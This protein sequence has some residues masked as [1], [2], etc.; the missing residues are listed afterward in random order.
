MAVSR[1]TTPAIANL[2]ITQAKIASSVDL[3]GAVK[4]ANVQVA[5]SSWSLLDDTAVDTDGGYV[6]VNGT[7]FVSGCNVLVGNVAATSVTFVSATQLRVQVPATAAGSYIM[8]VS[9]PDGATGIRLNAITFSADPQWVTDST[10]A[11]QITDSAIS[12]QLSAT[13]ATSYSLQAGS[14][15]PANTTLAS[16]G[17]FSGTITG[18]NEDTVYNFTVV[19]TDAENQDSPRAFSVTVTVGDTYFKETVL[20]LNSEANTL[21][22]DASNNSF[23]ITP[24]GDVRPSAFSPYN[25]N[26]SNFFN[27]TGEL[28]AP[29]SAISGVGSSN[30]SIECWVY[31]TIQTNT[32]A[33]GLV[34]YGVF[35]STS[36]TSY[37]SFQLSSSGNLAVA[38]ATGATLNLS[39]P[40]LFPINQW[41]HAVVCR[42]GSTLSLFVNGTRVATTTTSATV[43]SSGD[44]LVIGGQWYAAVSDRRLQGYISNVRIVNGSSAYDATSSTLTVPTASLTAIANTTLLT[45]QSNRLIDNSTNAFTITKTGDT[46]VSSFGPFTETDVTTGSGYFDGSGDYLSVADNTAL[47]MG[48]SNFTMECWVYLNEAASSSDGIFAKRADISTYGGVIFYINSTTPA[49]RATTNGSSWGVEISSSITISI[50]T[51]NH[52]AIT[53]SGST[54]TIWV[55]G[56]SGATAT[57]SGT[58]P[59]NSSAFVIGAYDSGG[60]ASYI[61]P[62]G[63]ISNARVV[64]GTA[65]YTSAFTP[66]T[67]PLTAVANTQLLTLQNRIGYNNH[68]FV[69]SAGVAH[70]ITRNGNAS[71]GS[72]SPFSPTGWSGYF[73][74]TG[75]Y[76]TLSNN[77][78]FN[79]G[80]GDFTVEF[81][82]NQTAALSSGGVA[83]VYS[84]QFDGSDTAVCYV[85]II[86]SGGTYYPIA[87]LRTVSTSSGTEYIGNTALSLNT[88]N[89]IALTRSGTTG[90]LFL[91]GAVANTRTS[92]TQNISLN[93]LL[94]IGSYNGSTEMATGYISNLRIIKGNAL[95]TTTFTPPT[96]LLPPIANTQLLMLRSG[97]FVDESAN[98]LAITRSG[99]VRVVPFSPFK[100]HTITANSH[101]VYF[102]GTGDFASVSGSGELVNFGTN[103]FTIEAWFNVSTLSTAFNIFDTCPLSNSSPTNR[104][105]IRVNTSGALQYATF[106][107][108]T[109]LITSSNSVIL[110]NIWNHVALV[111]SSGSTK[112]YL[113]GIQVGS[114]YTDSLNYPAQANRPI[115][116]GDGFNATALGTGYISNLHVVKGT[117]VYTANF[118]VPTT[119][120]TAIANTQLLTC[121]STSIID[122]STNAFTITATGNATASKFN[123]FGEAVTQVVEYSPNTHGGSVYLDGND[124]LEYSNN[125]TIN[126]MRIGTSNWTVEG[127]IYPTSTGSTQ[128][129]YWHYGTTTDILALRY[130]G[131]TGAVIGSL[132]ATN[133]AEQTLTSSVT[134]TINQ[135]IHVA[136]ARA[137]TTTV[138]LFTNGILSNTLT[139]TAT[140]SINDTALYSFTLGC[141]TNPVQNYFTGYMSDW[142]YTKGRC[143]YTTSFVPPLQSH[144]SI[145]GTHVLQKF[146]AGTIVDRSGRATFETIGNASTSS[147]IKK[148]GTGAMYFDGTGDTLLLPRGINNL[149][150]TA[151]NFTLE[152]WYRFASTPGA[153]QYVY[154]VR[155]D[156]DNYLF[157]Y[158]T[159]SGWVFD[160]FSNGGQG[161]KIT[162]SSLSHDNTTFHH[163]A[164]VYNSGTYTMYVDGSSVGSQANSS[165]LTTLNGYAV[166]LPYYIGS[167]ANIDS[168]FNGY[169]DDFRITKGVARYTSNF[170]APSALQT[171]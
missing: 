14:S 141:S 48:S 59:D 157:I 24:S 121:Q 107:A 39:D 8:Y 161:P 15:L 52:L 43:G 144:Q 31:L 147:A 131:S 128:Y 164:L 45:C 93:K 86:N 139:I 63:L 100:S 72:F 160:T 150:I 137:N 57:V 60:N 74:G 111:K 51:W 41:V 154:S 29:E 18:I 30:F 73:D 148:Y 84:Y 76:L 132:R 79:F 13:D 35:G 116:M 40:S 75:D 77:E 91:N 6:L 83:R 113:N 11:S 129:F 104:I 99:D 103:N 55:N 68:Q 158:A 170:T 80:T 96:S 110:T 101:S 2:A 92:Q 133:L 171:K 49:L 50:G 155:Q 9:N 89:H 142:R 3:G 134:H 98:R 17:L 62:S 10:L 165:V 163:F 135:W 162:S 90:R 78:G 61:L 36:G 124:Y 46:K 56:A 145:Q 136:M 127:W 16:N 151:S 138:R 119:P 126:D 47:D 69:D 7:N 159:S 152:F 153:S 54:W 58:V 146:T 143:L 4:I 71:Q 22:R 130:N 28:D 120:L 53:R 105:I 66:P 109:V 168:Y 34:S 23:N 12:V 85:G 19:A 118:T 37:I 114:T 123:P 125:S 94:Y 122:N 1:I 70:I 81:W 167:R 140:S 5:N 95:Y 21:I 97:S 27:R 25:T 33:Q 102:D 88:W 67:A 44:V 42:S 112:L 156:G 108:V 38:Y 65:V 115:L 64:K 87:F 32:Y 117:A 26:W 106:Q 82:V 20:L 166:S 149:F 169:L